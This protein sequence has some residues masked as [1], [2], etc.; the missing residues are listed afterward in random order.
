M[1]KNII[2]FSMGLLFAAGVARAAG[3]T[4]QAA[5][6]NNAETRSLPESFRDAGMKAGRT[7]RDAFLATGDFFKEFGVTVGR[8]GKKVISGQVEFWKKCGHS[9]I[10]FEEQP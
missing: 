10:G 5:A 1:T 2:I 8:G 6:P 4:E 7:S 9:L 3:K